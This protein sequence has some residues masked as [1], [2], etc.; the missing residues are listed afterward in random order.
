V[1]HLPVGEGC[2]TDENVLTMSIHGSRCTGAARFRARARTEEEGQLRGG[3]SPAR[4]GVPAK[5]GGEVVDGAPH[6][7]LHAPQEVR[8]ALVQKK[9]GGRLSAR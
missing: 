7:V 4:R 1:A 8:D 2:P 3:G 9:G 5:G 6:K